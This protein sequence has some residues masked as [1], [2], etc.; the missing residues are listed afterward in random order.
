[1]LPRRSGREIREAKPRCD[2][3][4]ANHNSALPAIVTGIER[5]PGV[6]LPCVVYQRYPAAPAAA[7]FGIYVSGNWYGGAATS[8]QGFTA[9]VNPNSSAFA[10]LPNVSSWSILFAR[11]SPASQAVLTGGP[12]DSGMAL[13]G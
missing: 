10:S 2:S 13:V 1:M 8:G 7:P 6:K 5:M 12:V 11:T 3:T 4:C 9:V